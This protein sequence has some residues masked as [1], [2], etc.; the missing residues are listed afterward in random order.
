MATLQSCYGRNHHGRS[1]K[2]IL[3][4]SPSGRN[5]L[6]WLKGIA[7]D[8]CHPKATQESFQKLSNRSLKLR[9]SL[10][11]CNVEYRSLE[12]YVDFWGYFRGKYV[13]TDITYKHDGTRCSSMSKDFP[14]SNDNDEY[15]TGSNSL[16]WEDITTKEY[17]TPTNFNDMVQSSESSSAEVPAHKKNLQ[18]PLGIIDSVQKPTAVPNSTAGKSI[19]PPAKAVGKGRHK[20]CSCAS[21]GSLSCNR[22]HVLESRLLLKFEIGPAFLSWKFDKMG[23]AVLKAWTSE[24]QCRFESFVKTNPLMR[25]T[26]FWEL[27]LKHFPSKSKKSLLSY[28]YNVYMPRS[29]R[30]QTRSSLDDLCSDDD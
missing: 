3:P 12:K 4:D 16:S 1:E 6:A 10:F 28:Y 25:V 30:L 22:R 11:S 17:S 2:G 19:K 24:E 23:E 15:L 5:T 18:Q 13:D 7:L 29:M 26:N 14:P 21:P 8:P 20:L 9:K 27:A